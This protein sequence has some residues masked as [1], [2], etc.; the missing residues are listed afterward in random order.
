MQRTES[1][2]GNI[3]GITKHTHRKILALIFYTIGVTIHILVKQL[4]S[5]K[6]IV[7]SCS[8]L[9]YLDCKCI[10][11]YRVCSEVNIFKE[12]FLEW[13]EMGRGLAGEDLNY[14]RREEK[15]FALS[16]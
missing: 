9:N 1:R 13:V 4:E 12:V 2:K 7:L 8:Q 5:K 16:Q 15:A 14:Q 11:R 6:R 10:F 3:H